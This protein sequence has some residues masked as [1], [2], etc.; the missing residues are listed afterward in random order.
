MA[1]KHVP[2]RGCRR[3]IAAAGC[4]VLL[5][6]CEQALLAQSTDTHLLAANTVTVGA[7]WQWLLGLVVLATSGGFFFAAVRGIR[8]RTH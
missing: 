8:L 5:F 6:F 2:S 1:S 4:A 7:G 3:R